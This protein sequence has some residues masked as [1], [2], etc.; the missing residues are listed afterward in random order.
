MGSKYRITVIVNSGCTSV[1]I[2]D[3]PQSVFRKRTVNL[4]ITHKFSSDKE[5][6]LDISE[7]G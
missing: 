4:S 6:E 5:S 7:A 1:V 3:L 2:A